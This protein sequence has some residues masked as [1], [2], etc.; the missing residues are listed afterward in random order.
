VVASSGRA[1][2]IA[3]AAR[4]N[5]DRATS[6]EKRLVTRWPLAA[7]YLLG[8]LRIVTGALFFMHGS[9]KLLG[10]PAAV[11]HAVPL[12]S[13][14]GLAGV[15]ETVGGALLV[16]GLF[17]RVVAFI[18]SGE[19]AFAYF[20]G[21]APRGFLPIVNKGELA[22]VWCFLFLYFSAAGAGAFSIDAL[23]RG[24]RAGAMPGGLRRDTV[25]R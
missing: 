3:S 18:L 7:P 20:I 25:A 13:L 23:R 5:A 8:I 24:D 6:T 9:S 16:L 4:S 14:A 21:H 2:N 1:R 12:M 22:V 19:M 11:A 17:T 15:L 10:F